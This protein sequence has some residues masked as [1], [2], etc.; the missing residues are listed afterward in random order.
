MFQSGK[1][2]V[3][4]DFIARE[5]ELFRLKTAVEHQSNMVLIAPRR[6][7]KLKVLKS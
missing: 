1:P 3:A 2:V 5:E 6:Y 7:G 4:N